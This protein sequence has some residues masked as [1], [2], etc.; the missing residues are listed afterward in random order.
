MKPLL[1][2]VMLL[3]ADTC[4][5]PAQTP[6]W[7]L[8]EC[9]VYA[10]QH[11]C[12]VLLQ[13]IG[14]AKSRQKAALSKLE[15]LPT[16][17][18]HANQ[19]YNWGRSV[20]MQE[21]VIVKNRLT[22]QTSASIGASLSLFDGFATINTITMNRCLAEAASQAVRQT[23]F[24][25]K[26]EVARAYLANILAKLTRERL[27]DSYEKICLQM[28]RLESAV[29]AGATKTSDLMEM[30]AKAA[31]VRSQI[32]SAES[33]ERSRMQQLKNLMAC[34]D[35]FDTGLEA[36]NQSEA[37]APVTFEDGD[38]TPPDVYAARSEAK[39]AAMALKVAR[40]ALFPSL[41]LSAG[42]GT[43]Y[44]DAAGAPFMEQLDG[45]R[46]PSVSLTLA[47]PLFDSGRRLTAIAGAKADKRLSEVKLRQASEKAALYKAD[48]LEEYHL[49]LQQC[50][51]CR[52]KCQLQH[53]RMAVATAE[54]EL[55]AMTTS[56]W[57]DAGEAL[58]ESECEMVQ[59]MCKY[60][61]QVKIMEY[62]RDGCRR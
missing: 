35:L 29:A 7:S 17:S 60:L 20:D 46:N 53:K 42:Y 36:E 51:I 1:C 49:L 62:Y 61:F 2:A 5:L 34:N 10:L 57:I 43:Y 58:A 56:Q 41:T 45:N 6:V 39:A 14:E 3:L 44:S 19:Y 55:G 8:D 22:R 25:V 30:E 33:E 38:L 32:A 16:L 21:L 24:E 37:V 13:K 9:V 47:I 50:E 31:D 11:N 40:G 48:M 59:Y 52:Q 18:F 15:L 54:Y 28:E 23:E 26:A 12:E 27:K 4:L